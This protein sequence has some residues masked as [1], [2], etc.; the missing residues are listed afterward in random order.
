[1]P[2][3]E[4]ASLSCSRFFREPEYSCPAESSIPSERAVIRPYLTSRPGFESNRKLPQDLNPDSR[5]KSEAFPKNPKKR[6][7]YENNR[8]LEITPGIKPVLKEWLPF[9]SEKLGIFVKN[10]VH[11]PNP[12]ILPDGSNPFWPGTPGKPNEKRENLPCCPASWCSSKIVGNNPAAGSPGRHP[13]VS[14]PGYLQDYLIIMRVKMVTMRLPAAG[15]SMNLNT[16]F[17]GTLG[18]R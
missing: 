7:D 1:M 17:L 16:A 9:H 8:E 6:F 13:A 11:P 12:R 18:L 2:E 15:Q 3:K 10:A 14:F 4:I 5:Q